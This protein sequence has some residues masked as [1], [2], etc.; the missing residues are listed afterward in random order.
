[1]IAHVVLFSPRPDLPDEQRRALVAAFEA[2]LR[3][4][5]VIRRARVGGRVT[6]GRPYEQLMSVDYQYAAILEFDSVDDLKAYLNHP[7]HEQ[8][9]TRFFD[10]FDEALMYDYEVADGEDGIK[11]VTSTS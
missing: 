9:A 5:P 3:D 1:M 8:L 2:A 7:A 11:A 6:H 4:I 10:A